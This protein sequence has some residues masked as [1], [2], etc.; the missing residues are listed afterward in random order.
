LAVGLGEYETAK[1]IASA[2]KAGLRFP[3]HR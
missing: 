2:T 3:R 1:T